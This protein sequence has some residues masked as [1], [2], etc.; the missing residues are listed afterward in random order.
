MAIISK[1]STQKRRGRYNIFLDGQY[2]FSVSQK[3]VA[4]FVLLKG[5]ELTSFEIEKIKQFDDNARASDLAA[6]F[7]S[8]EPRTVYEVLQYLNKHEITSVAATAAVDELSKLGYL[9]DE[10]YTQLFIQNNLKIGSD[11]PFALSRKLKQKGVNEEIIDNALMKISN[12]DWLTIGQRLVKTMRSKV[13][14]ISEYEL[15]RKIKSKLL[16]HGFNSEI[17]QEVID[18][19]EINFAPTAQLDALKQQGIKAYK[20]FRKLDDYQRK[21]KIKRYLFTHGFSSNEIDSFLAGEIIDLT[22]LKEY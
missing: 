16:T 9:D 12:T 4:E 1:I 11:G 15:K 7:L 6:R 20:K 14:K 19:L 5:K 3:T 13:G 2:A 17:A 22:E 21:F 10:N 8:Y 18:Q